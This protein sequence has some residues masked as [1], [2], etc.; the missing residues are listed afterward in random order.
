VSA[1][2]AGHVS[3]EGRV[4]LDGVLAQARGSLMHLRVD[5][6]GLHDRPSDEDLRRLAVDGFVGRAVDALRAEASPAADDAL[7]LL[8]RFVIEEGR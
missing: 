5:A 3:L 4:R 1:S 6:T 8:H 2:F 7:R